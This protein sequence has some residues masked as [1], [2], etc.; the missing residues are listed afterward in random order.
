MVN[1]CLVVTCY[2]HFW[3]KDRDHLHATAVTRG[4]NILKDISRE[5]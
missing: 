4:W 2:L 5:S 3:Q 1:V